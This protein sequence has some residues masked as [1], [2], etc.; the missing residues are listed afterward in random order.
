M[1]NIISG[2]ISII[3]IIIQINLI[4]SKTE[5]TVI[6]LGKES[7]MFIAIFFL[8]LLITLHINLIKFTTKSH[9]KLI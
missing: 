6:E 9:L 1:N 2:I 8:L 7:Y 4:H 5:M 3:S